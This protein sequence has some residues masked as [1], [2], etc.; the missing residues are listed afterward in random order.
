MNTLTVPSGASKEAIQAHYDL[1]NDFYRL[2][3]DE[4]MVYS[5]ALWEA[6][7]SL[8]QAQ[9]R[10]LDHHIRAVGAG[11]GHRILDVGC[12]WGGMLRRLVSAHGVAEAVGLTLSEAQLRYVES[13]KSPGIRVHLES[14]AD[15]H[16]EAPYDGIIS[17]GA[18]EHFA[19]LEYSEAEKVAAYGAFFQACRRMLRP[20]GSLS[21]QTFAY[22]SR[23]PRAEV[24]GTESTRFLAA[25]IFQET[26]PPHL[27]NI[28]EA[29]L[30]AFEIR[31]LTNAREDYAQTCRQWLARLEARQSEAMRRVGQAEVARYRRYLQLS[32]L[33]FATGGLDLY[34][35]VLRRVP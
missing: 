3:L 17:V 18:F 13:A 23:R 12:G 8:D 21:L 11:P 29:I 6:G 27:A 9:L 22:G 14:W 19:R 32:L 2:W 20:G 5:G 35:I 15:H 28:A 24:V 31:S 34:R 1:D 30:G 25:E 16:P 10:K 7:D 26:D 33:A 4:E